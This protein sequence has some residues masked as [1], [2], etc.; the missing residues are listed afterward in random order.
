MAT[1]EN[2]PFLKRCLEKDL[3]IPN[4]RFKSGEETELFCE[5]QSEKVV[6]VVG[7]GGRSWKSSYQRY[8]SSYYGSRKESNI[9]KSRIG[10]KRREVNGMKENFENVVSSD[11][12]KNSENIKVSENTEDIE[13]IDSVTIEELVVWQ[14]TSGSDAFNKGFEVSDLNKIEAFVEEDGD[15]VEQFWEAMKSVKLLSVKLDSL[16]MKM[17]KYQIETMKIFKSM[18]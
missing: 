18:K 1:S 16:I 9:V 11:D 6:R 10:N 7:R 13:N 3:N 15:V 12:I 8:R 14:P 17:K 4:K 2:R 5:I